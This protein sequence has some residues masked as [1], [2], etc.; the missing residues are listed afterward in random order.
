MAPGNGQFN[1]VSAGKIMEKE[2]SRMLFCVK[3]RGL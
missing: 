2:C 1:E 3:Y